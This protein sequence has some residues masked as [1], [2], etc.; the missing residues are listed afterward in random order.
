MVK[1]DRK[2]EAEKMRLE[3][4]Q[5][6]KRT[7]LSVLQVKTQQITFLNS[8]HKQSQQCL[9]PK[10][11]YC[12]FYTTVAFKSLFSLKKMKLFLIQF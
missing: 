4:R 7:S 8:K 3:R 5:Q 11:C 9:S 1:S 2:K 6:R 10:S 12:V